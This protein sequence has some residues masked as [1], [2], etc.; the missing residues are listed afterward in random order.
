MDT[1][2]IVTKAVVNVNFIM[3]LFFCM[4][5]SVKESFAF[6]IAFWAT[7]CL[8]CGLPHI[9]T[10]VLPASVGGCRAVGVKRGAETIF[11][12][13]AGRNAAVR[14]PPTEANAAAFPRLKIGTSGRE[15]TKAG[16]SDISEAAV[17]V[18]ARWSRRPHWL[19]FGKRSM[20]A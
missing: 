1:N 6:A 11:R 12:N 2:A 20:P 15:L 10:F 18:P 13:G 14:E 4:N 16:R 3:S 8:P 9:C 5:A 17:S 7:N 19:R